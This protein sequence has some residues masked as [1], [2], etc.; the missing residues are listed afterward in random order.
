[1]P[2]ASN[3]F[4]VDDHQLVVDGLEKLIGEEAD[5]RIVGTAA[6]GKEAVERIPM[7][8]PDLVL[9]DMDMPG[10]NGMEASRTL[11]KAHPDIKIAMLTMH[12][13]R[14]LVEKLA[15]FG[16]KGYFLKHADKLEFIQGIRLI[17]AG[18]KYFQAEAMLSPLTPGKKLVGGK[19]EVKLLAELSER[20]QEVL[21]YI[22][23]GYTSNEIAAELHISSRTVE[24]HRK[25]IHQKLGIPKLAGLIRFGIKSG[26]VE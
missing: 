20:E 24:T 19:E 1:M 14:G 10:M 16:V 3:I 6:N 21:R 11:L 8:K 13:D 12:A 18:K 15:E 9:M 25:N 2:K 17:L 23:L 7:I 22:A 5:L 4:I 26:L